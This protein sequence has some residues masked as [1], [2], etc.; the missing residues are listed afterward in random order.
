MGYHTQTNGQVY[1]NA[2]KRILKKG[3]A[4]LEREF[5]LK[6]IVGSELPEYSDNA[7]NDALSSIGLKW[8]DL[9]NFIEFNEDVRNLD[10]ELVITICVAITKTFP[11]TRGTVFFDGEES[12]DTWIICIENG[13][14][15]KKI[16]E[17]IWKTTEVINAKKGER[18]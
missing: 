11:E 1:L 16:G 12:G 5:K 10:E 7:F 6:R 8:N 13:I 2:N 17:L 18:K 3:R 4:Q 14:V 9:D 15:T